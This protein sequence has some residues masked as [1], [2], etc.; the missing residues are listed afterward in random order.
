[1]LLESPLIIGN[2]K[3]EFV[4]IEILKDKNDMPFIPGTSVI[5]VLRHYFT[6][7]FP[8]K[9]GESFNYFWDSLKKSKSDNKQNTIQSAF[10]CHD[11]YSTDAKIYVRDGVR[12]N[13]AKQIAEDKGK[14]DFEIIDK[15]ASFDLFWKLL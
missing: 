10:I 4:D 1:L 13:S 6:D 5:G 12:I 7:N 15:G 3:S 14:Y 8:E 9:R 2:G 11:L